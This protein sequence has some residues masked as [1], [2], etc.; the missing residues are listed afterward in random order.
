M[1]TLKHHMTPN[2][3]E[4]KRLF[5]LSGP[6]LVDPEYGAEPSIEDMI[7]EYFVLNHIPPERARELKDLYI[8]GWLKENMGIER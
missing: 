5:S 1:K 7:Y 4:M 3:Q 2:K 6:F 8:S